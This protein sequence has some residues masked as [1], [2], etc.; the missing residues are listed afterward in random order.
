VERLAD[1]NAKIDNVEKL[2]AVVTAIRGIAAARAQEARAL[3]VGVESYARIVAAAIGEALRLPYAAGERGGP[4]RRGEVVF[5]AEQGFAGAFSDRVLDLVEGD[6]AE[7]TVLIVGTRGAAIAAERGIEAD[8]TTAM[9]TQIS[10]VRAG[11]DRLASA[12]YALIEQLG[13]TRIGL[14]FAHPAAGGGFAVQ[15]QSLLP[16]D[17]SQFVPAETGYP[18]LVNLPPVTLVQQ[19]VDE[20]VYAR[21]CAA[22]TLAF[23]AENEARLAAMISART[24]VETTLASLRNRASQARQEEVTEEV[25]ALSASAAAVS[26]AA[27]RR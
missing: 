19:L 1:I 3:L 7:A 9:A 27:S 20:Y 24:N 26:A 22:A 14:T 4:D 13:L 15:R 17:L 2:D 8:W 6:L 12:L 10:G 25:I 11:A 18:P 16:L 21:L 23:A 5:V